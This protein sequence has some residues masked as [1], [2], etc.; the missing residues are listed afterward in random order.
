MK[1]KYYSGIWDKDLREALE[2]EERAI[3]AEER[4]IRIAKLLQETDFAEENVRELIIYMVNF[5]HE[6]IA[7][8][9]E[10]IKKVCPNLYE[11]I[12]QMIRIESKEKTPFW[13][14]PTNFFIEKYFTDVMEAP[15]E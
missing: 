2:A 1:Q 12:D 4:E 14:P 9:F 8:Y 6:Q 10:K 3:E 7:N 15:P 13:R 11:A 5:Q